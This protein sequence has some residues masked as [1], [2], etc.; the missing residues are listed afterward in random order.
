MKILL[1]HKFFHVTG[2]AEVFFFETGRVLAAQGHDV[3]YFS[4]TSDENQP[5]QF[6]GYF[7]EPPNYTQGSLLKR[8][9]GIGRMVYSQEAKRNFRLLLEDFQPDLV[10]VFAIQ[11]HISPSILD[12]CT[13]MNVPVVMS[14]NDYKH[15]CPNYKL[16][17]HGR[18]RKL[19]T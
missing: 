14:C 3:A 4:T 17:H 7:V 16:F 12:V 19:S 2:G 15:I 18:L 10:H 9:L 11:T 6:S 5:S 13:E 8:S 1:V